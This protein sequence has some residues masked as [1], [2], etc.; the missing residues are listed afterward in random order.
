VTNSFDSVNKRYESTIAGET[1]DI[2]KYMTVATP[3]NSSAPRFISTQAS[4]GK[5]LIKAFDLTGAAVQS[6]FTFMT[7]KP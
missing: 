6:P 4:G 2:N 7:Y 1:Y 5:L 3:I